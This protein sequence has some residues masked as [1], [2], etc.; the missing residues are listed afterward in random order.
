MTTTDL[1]ARLDSMVKR[2]DDLLQ[3][4]QRLLGR[5]EEAQRSLDELRAKCRAKNIDPDN[6]DGV[7]VKLESALGRSLDSLESKLVEAEQAMEP[8]IN[9]RK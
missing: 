7:I 1:K 5:L 8:F 6:L 3:K 9:H 2:R 4:R